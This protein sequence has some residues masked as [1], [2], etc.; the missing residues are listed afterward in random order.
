MNL[1]SPADDSFP[2]HPILAELSALSGAQ[3]DHIPE[4]LKS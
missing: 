2:H 4:L 1:I 3:R